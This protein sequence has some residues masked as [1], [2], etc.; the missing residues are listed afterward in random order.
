[1]GGMRLKLNLFAKILLLV[2][3]P[4]LFELGFACGLFVMMQQLDV[5]ATNEHK[6]REALASLNS[7]YE[8]LMDSSK[9]VAGVF[10][11]NGGASISELHEI[12]ATIPGDVRSLR[13]TFSDDADAGELIDKL[14]RDL[15]ASLRILDEV[16]SQF[17]SGDRLGGF[18]H[19]RDL[20]H[21]IPDLT[22]QLND[23]RARC[24]KDAE[25]KFSQQSQDRRNIANLLMLAIAFN[26]IGAIAV[27][28][29]AHRNITSRL[30][31]VAENTRRVPLGQPLLPPVGGADEIA[32]LD[33][34]F[35]DMAVALEKAEAERK[36]MER[37]KQ[38]FVSMISHDLR[39]P[40]TS[41]QVFVN[42]LSKGLMGQVPEPVTKK[43]QM[44]DRNATRLIGLINDLLDIDKMESGQLELSLEETSLPAIIERSVESVRGFAEK[45]GILIEWRGCEPITVNADGDRIVQVMVNL[46]G[47][48]VKFSPK[49][50]S[51]RIAVEKQGAEARVA[52]IDKGR[53]VPEHLRTAIFERFKQVSTKDATEKKG[54]GLG[55]AICKAIVEQH[56]GVIG[57]DSVEG[58]G[59]TFWFKLPIRGND[60]KLADAPERAKSTVPQ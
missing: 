56:G 6:A 11:K 7:I 58:Q 46:L 30:L 9:L 18:Q 44:A 26:V 38:E 49:D 22:L 28:I 39:T 8:R 2:G 53:G 32:H 55:L 4:L 50:A 51:V 41:I 48:A 10:T 40:L 47:N 23:L 13:D 3:V 31:V 42:M 24:L 25:L 16:F 57:C 37:M 27:A 54:T 21:A 17:E 33:T 59:S 29:Y 19:L 12:T 1:M 5:A 60:A 15:N 43:A 52:V 20:K 34:T 14:E 36:E 35:K 45:E